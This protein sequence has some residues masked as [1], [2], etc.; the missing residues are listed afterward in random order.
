LIA[1]LVGDSRWWPA[2]LT[3]RESPSLGPRVP[4]QSP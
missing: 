4:I 2:S 3:R 1:D